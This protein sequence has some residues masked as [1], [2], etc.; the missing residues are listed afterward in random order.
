MTKAVRLLLC[1]AV[2]ATASTLQSWLPGGQPTR[3]VRM[4]EVVPAVDATAPQTV[5]LKA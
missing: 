4:A 5:T 3:K 2:A 1:L